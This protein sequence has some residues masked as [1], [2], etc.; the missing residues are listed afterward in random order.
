[1]RISSMISDLLIKKQFHFWLKC[2]SG[3]VDCSGVKSG[4]I[5]P[6][7]SMTKIYPFNST[8]AIRNSP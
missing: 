8:F 1:Q 7:S 5:Q 4:S 2:W 3:S 6:G